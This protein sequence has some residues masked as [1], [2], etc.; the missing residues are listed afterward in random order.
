[1]LFLRNSFAAR[2]Q[3]S[4]ASRLAW[5]EIA[6]SWKTDAPRIAALVKNPERSEVAEYFA[7]AVDGDEDHFDRSGAP[8]ILVLSGRKPLE[9]NYDLRA[10]SDPIWGDGECNWE[11]EVCCLSDITPLREVLVNIAHMTDSSPGEAAV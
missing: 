10:F 6:C 7:L 2:T 3:P 4:S 9:L 11:S 5:R 8:T 1:V